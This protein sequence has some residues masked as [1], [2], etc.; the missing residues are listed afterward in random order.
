MRRLLVL[1]GLCLFIALGACAPSPSQ[2]YTTGKQLLSEDFSN[3]DAWETFSL[4]DQEQFAIQD[5]AYNAHSDANGFLWGLNQTSH[6]DVVMEVVTKQNS[7]YDDNFYGLIC[8]ADTSDNGDGY[9]FL[10][11]GDG[12]S[13]IA[14]GHEDKIDPLAGPADTGTINKGTSVNHIR[15]VCIGDYLAL[16]VNDSFVIEAHDSHYS[17][18]YAGMAVSANPSDD[19]NADVRVDVSFDDLL[20]LEASLASQ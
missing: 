18:G 19:V 7:S 10:I 4:T 12:Y 14:Y 2:Q 16:Y 6:S 13:T 20:I 17:S 5:G 1:P 9:Y 3:E 11:S 15:A 8:R